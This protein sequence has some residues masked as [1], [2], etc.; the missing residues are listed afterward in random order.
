[1]TGDSFLSGKL[2]ADQ[3]PRGPQGSAIGGSE[4][5]SPP[6][7]SV[8]RPN[9]ARRRENSAIPNQ[10]L[11]S[12]RAGLMMEIARPSQISRPLVKKDETVRD[13]PSPK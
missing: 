13:V 11:Q 7:L 6:E 8:R 12:L 5:L 9:W 10:A 3:L 4:G 2:S 1:M